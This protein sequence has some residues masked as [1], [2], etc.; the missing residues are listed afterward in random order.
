MAGT[1]V[2]GITIELSADASGVS[3]A[4]K[5]VNSTLK[6]TQSD[7]KDI[8]KLLKLDP[9]N[10]ELLA[11]KHKALE[12]ALEA[13]KDKVEVLRQAEE[14]LA[15]QM[16][17]GGTEEQQRQ[18]E[19]LQRE[20]VS[21][22]ADMRKYENALAETGEAADDS[23]KKTSNFGEVAKKAGEVAAAAFAAVAA[24]AVAVVK[25][26]GDMVMDTAEYG[27]NVD[28]MSQK[29]GM[30][31]QAYQEWAYVLEL[32]GTD[33][34]SM[35]T[36]MKT[37][38]N[39][40]DD[41]KNGSK[42]AAAMFEKL[43]I[44]MEDLDSMSRE[45]AF[46]AVVESM[47]GMA[48]STERAALA[49]DLFGKSGQEL[50]PLF[51]QTSEL[52]KEQI[53]NAE[54]L[55]MVMSDE[56]VKAAAAFQDSMTT[57]QGALTGFKN[58]LGAEFLPG[59]TK[60]MDGITEILAGNTEEG[61]ELIKQG[62]DDMVEVLTEMLPTFIEV[63]GEVI[64][65]LITGIA[66][67]LPDLIPA[68]VEVVLQIVDTLIDN[69]PLIIDAAIE[70]IL[71]I[72]KGLIDALPDLI[73]KVV[74]IIL[75]ICETLLDH[76]PEI[77]EAAI[78]LIIAL[79]T[80]LIKA[81]PTL[82]TYI[83]QIIWA[84]IKG[85]IEGIEYMVSA[86][87]ELLKGLWRGISAAAGWLWEKISGWLS[88][89][90][91]GILGFF[92][93]QSPSKEMAWVGEMLTEGLAGGIKDNADETIKAAEDMAEDVLDAVSGLD[94]TVDVGMNAAVNPN[95]AAAYTTQ[96][97]S[98]AGILNLLEKYLPELADRDVML[99]GDTIVGKLAS[100]YNKAFG[101]MDTL[102]ARGV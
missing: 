65:S 38:T 24:A 21:T 23:A 10:T 75:T 85:L 56:S 20:I 92:G 62:A 7:L 83:P 15:A 49:N 87:W 45:D 64:I 22:E 71:A 88:G 27:D 86:G 94:T 6:Q 16:E 52:T 74:E 82:V 60:A 50:T 68:I 57:M 66:E 1:K 97:T 58:K 37:L 81:I 53:A 69:L 17:D 59:V 89:L 101:R 79:A 102:A 47:Q 33:I 98:E 30:S 13:T 61:I 3:S 55:G 72:A 51:N 32:A 25:G 96:V 77:I 54:R 84:I 26:L 36:G 48:D 100:K 9:G 73:P 78:Q 19:A 63:G 34:D 41:A 4:L 18:M 42:T 11:Q 39:K 67:S 95:S 31:T 28:K 40:I 80:G 91:E 76:L 5:D 14:D 43:G 12:K 93:I 2:R 44:S 8:D 90:W 46:A 99:D 70:I 35:S 29:L